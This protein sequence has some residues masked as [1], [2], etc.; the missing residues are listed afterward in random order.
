M[1]LGSFG[2]LGGA[3]ENGGVSSETR[4]ERGGVGHWLR[5]SEIRVARSFRQ[6]DVMRRR[7][8]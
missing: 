3:A 7:L 1:G 6:K 5:V 8:W 4:L 2:I